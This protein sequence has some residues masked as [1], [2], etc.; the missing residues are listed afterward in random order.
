M[1]A[2]YPE[3]LLL[4]EA[5]PSSSEAEGRW[6]FRLESSNGELLLEAEDFEAADPQRL[7]LLAVVRGLESLEGPSRVT[8]IVAN[9]YVLQGMRVGLA[10]WRDTDF[11]WEHF[12]RMLPVVHADLW[13]RVDRALAIHEVQACWIS[14]ACIQLGSSL[15]GAPAPTPIGAARW[16][17]KRALQPSAA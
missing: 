12:G 17:S 3:Y 13:R 14:S 16:L 6:H 5:F 7:A 9:R 15:M 10:T 1:V 11:R 8:L 4:C 2:Y